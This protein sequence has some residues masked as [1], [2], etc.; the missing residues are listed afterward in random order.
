M[1]RDRQ[2][3]RQKPLTKNLTTI[4][5]KYRNIFHGDSNSEQRMQISTEQVNTSYEFL[6]I[7][8][9]SVALL[10]PYDTTPVQSSLDRLAPVF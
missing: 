1:T 4:V 6:L 9:V 8:L 7:S 2:L 10:T 3:T 5:Q